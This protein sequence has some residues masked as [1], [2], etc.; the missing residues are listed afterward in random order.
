MRWGG[1]ACH[2]PTPGI[3]GAADRR[4]RGC[5]GVLSEP[6]VRLWTDV[7]PNHE[8]LLLGVD[9]SFLQEAFM[10]RFL[11]GQVARRTRVTLSAALLLMAMACG[12]TPV[13]PGGSTSTCQIITGVT[14]TT[15]AAAGGSASIAVTTPASCAWT[16]VSSAAFLTVTQGASG[17]G[18][19]TV[20]FTVSANT[21]AQ[22]TAT[23]TITGTAIAITQSAP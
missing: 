18:N 6:P 10:K 17:S 7:G 14:T 16:A 21:G 13:A 22:R 5:S 20:Q 15:F 4:S 12:S 3:T 19:G 23:L 1:H 11:S 2:D 8:S 9:D